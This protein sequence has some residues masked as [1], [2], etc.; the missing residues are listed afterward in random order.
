MS[1]S[2]LQIQCNPYRSSN[3]FFMQKMERLVLNSYGGYVWAQQHGLLTKANLAI[4][5]LS[6]QSA[7]SRERYWASSM[8]LVWLHW[9]AS[10]MEEAALCSYWNKHFGHGFDFPECNASAKTII[11][12]LTECLIYHHSFPHSISSDKGTPFTANKVQQLVHAHDNSLV[13]LCSPFFS[14]VSHLCPLLVQGLKF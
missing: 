4:L 2:N 14:L 10:I 8:A 12:G 11:L 13:L 9:T 5:L 1:Q 7:S 3:N 6:A